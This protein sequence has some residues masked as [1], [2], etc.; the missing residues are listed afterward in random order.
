V[1][2][3]VVG[4][5]I[6]GLASA[7]SLL[8]RGHA[9]TLV[10]Q[11]EIPNSDGSSVDQHRLIRYPYGAAAGYTRMVAE[12][13]A[14]WEQL[15]ADIGERLYVETGSLVLTSGDDRW[16]RDS[17][18]CLRALGHS[19]EW[20]SREELA[21]RFPL[22]R[23]E[24]VQ[25]AFHLASGGVLL[26]SRIVA[27][28]ARQLRERGARLLTGVAVREIDWDGAT[29]TLTDAS[30]LRADA[31]VLAAGAWAPRL[32]PEL[33]AARVTPSR[34]VAAYLKPPADLAALWEKAPLVLDIDR[35]RGFYLVPPVLGTHLKV[36]DHHFTLTGDPDR[37]RRP[38]QAETRAVAE[39]SR[40]RLRD[41][42]RYELIEGKTCFYTVEPEERFLALARGR[43][44]VLS[45]CSGHA[46][47][48][49]P[50]IGAR[51][52]EAVSSGDVASLA[53]WAAG[54]D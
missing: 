26:A 14:H 5:G 29:V 7:W 31:L 53:R 46:F 23:S 22:L 11:K 45:A 33:L 15:F 6:M 8:R 44:L 30:Q 27:A 39:L 1:K 48:F 2:V 51:V 40:S 25:S 20:L 37:D 49:G 9:V 16:A 24:G 50:V 54:R 52:A 36:G 35:Q 10:E 12:A 13:Y 19:P 43:G 47:K 17:D 21:R 3:T 42:E 34:Q 41:F 18:V 38:S 32:V 28:L 4:A